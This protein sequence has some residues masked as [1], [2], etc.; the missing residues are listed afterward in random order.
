MAD[1][2]SYDDYKSLVAEPCNE[3]QFNKLIGGAESAIDNITRDYFKIHDLTGEPDRVV[4]D[5]KR[6]IA[7][8]VDFYNY[9]GSAKSYALDDES[10]KSVS[11]GR[12]TLQ[13]LSGKATS[14]NLVNGV[15]QESYNLLAKHGL[16][17]RGV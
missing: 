5:F 7:E 11:I 3:D 10:Y 14:D 1:Y 13:P 9:A 12:L 2:L 8:Q 4:K 16:L 17:W 6:A 15:V